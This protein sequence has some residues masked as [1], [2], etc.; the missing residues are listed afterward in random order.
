VG[1]WQVLDDGR[2][3]LYVCTSSA[4]AEDIQYSH[5]IKIV[6]IPQSVLMKVDAKSGKVMWQTKQAGQNCFLSGRYVYATKSTIDLSIAL[7]PENT[8]THF[9]VIRIDP[10]TG[11]RL[12]TY[13]Q[14]QTAMSLDF[15]NNL[16]LLQ[17]P[18]EVQVLKFTS[19]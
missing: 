5:Q 12:W 14:P 18:E 1:I 2:G 7:N 11:S 17:F 8:G 19:L 9:R 16:I 13:Y 3:S 6:E 10:K 4:G 15:T